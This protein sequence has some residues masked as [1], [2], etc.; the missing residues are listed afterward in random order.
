MGT[1]VTSSETVTKISL[2]YQFNKIL[3][4]RLR[5]IPRITLLNDQF[6][7]SNVD[8]YLFSTVTTGMGFGL[9]AA[10]EFVGNTWVKSKNDFFMQLQNIYGEFTY[11]PS[12]NASDSNISRGTSSSGSHGTDYRLGATALIW[13]DFVPFIKRFVVQASYGARAYGLKF[14]GAT[15][16]AGN[17]STTTILPNGASDESE[18]DYRFFIGVRFADPIQLMF[19]DKK[20]KE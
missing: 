19:A 5:L 7:T 1:V 11:Y 15:T 6:T 18:K 8:E 14:S 12:I 9:K 2:A 4:D 20:K 10:Y 3:K 13:L 16:S 17:G